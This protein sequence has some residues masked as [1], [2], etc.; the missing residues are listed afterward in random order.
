[1]KLTLTMN[2][3]IGMTLLTGALASGQGLGSVPGF[4]GIPG[5]NSPASQQVQDRRLQFLTD[6]L[7]LTTTQRAQAETIFTNQRNAA[8]PLA[9][10][11]Q[12]VRQILAAGA[13]AQRTHAEIDE[14]AA[15]LG[16]LTAQLTAIQVKA[17]ADFYRILTPEQQQK[18][19]RLQ[20]EGPRR[21]P[22][23]GA[24]D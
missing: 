15:Q 14:A 20:Q 21:L 17:Q 9:Q 3:L 19:D 11:M 8:G 7:G 24:R 18:L 4:P 16:A 6:Y 12:P 22:G 10:Q 2:R 5:R 23:F 13:K 1:M